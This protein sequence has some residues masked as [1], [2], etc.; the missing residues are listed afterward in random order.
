MSLEA[1][2]AELTEVTKQLLA[3][4]TEAIE[5]VKS[6]AVPATGKG[7]ASRPAE[8]AETADAAAETKRQ[9][10]DN[11]EDRTEAHADPIKKAITDYMGVEDAEERAACKA[12]VAEIMAKVG[13]K[14][15]T[16]IPAGK[17]KAFLNTMAKLIAAGDLIQKDEAP[18]GEEGDESDDDLLD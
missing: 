6:A 5:T 16:E 17:H 8:E 1:A 7:K 18:E 12:K 4:R 9:I 10:S 3:L 15:H 14:K 11:P 2:I 13:A